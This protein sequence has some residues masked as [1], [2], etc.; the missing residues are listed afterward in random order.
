MSFG[1]EVL[2]RTRSSGLISATLSSNLAKETTSL[3][4]YK[5]DTE[6]NSITNEEYIVRAEDWINKERPNK[7]TVDG[8]TYILYDYDFT[9]KGMGN[10]SKE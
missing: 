8:N 9:D 5:Y 7:I 10:G 1:C 2:K 3:V 6:N 4:F